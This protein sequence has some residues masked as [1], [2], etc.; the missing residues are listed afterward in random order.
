PNAVDLAAP[1]SPAPRPGRS[2]PPMLLC[3]G[4]GKPHKNVELLVRAL[5][6]VE[7]SV[8]LI[9]VGEG[10]ERLPGTKNIEVRAPVDDAALVALYREATLFLCPSRSE[11]FGLPPLEAASV[12]TPVLVAD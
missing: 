10:L 7:H 1:D 9:L 4:N 12:G 2:E 6:L 3:V 8:R 11:G 5:P